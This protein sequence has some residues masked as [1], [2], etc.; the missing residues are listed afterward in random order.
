MLHPDRF[1]TVL[2][3]MF[4][5]DLCHMQEKSTRLRSSLTSEDVPEEELSVEEDGA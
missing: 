4:P 5:K 1:A 3:V 2:R